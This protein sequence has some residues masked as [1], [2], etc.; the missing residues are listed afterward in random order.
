MKRELI[1]LAFSKGATRQAIT[2]KQL[3]EWAI[4]YPQGYDTQKEIVETIYAISER[5]NALQANYTKTIALCDDMK[6]ALLRKAF[7]GEL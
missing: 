4:Q 1:E 2:K 3:E 6:Q 5:C 7:S